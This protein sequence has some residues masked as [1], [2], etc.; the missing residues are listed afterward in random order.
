MKFSHFV[1][2][3]V[4]ST[5]AMPHAVIPF[6]DVTI[7]TSG[8]M[9][10]TINGESMELH[11]GDVIVYSPGDVRSRDAGGAAT[12]FSFNITLKEGTE[13]PRFHGHLINCINDEILSLVSL[14]E[15]FHNGYTSQEREKCKH[16]FL[17][18]YYIL[19]EI[20]TDAKQDNYISKIKQYVADHLSE[21]LSLSGVSTAVFLSPN[22]CNHIFKTQTGETIME[23]ALRV[24][25]ERARHLLLTSAMPLSE[26]AAAL[27][28]KQ[29]SYFSG[30]FK[31]EVGVSP[32]AFRRNAFYTNKAEE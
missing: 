3:K 10:Y 22:Y 8:V 17:M 14:Y 5:V 23:Y 15:R 13:Y 30:L 11:A 12:Y 9:H 28:Y 18:L 32:A 21:P 7:V 6:I 29:Y 19:Y 16:C 31:K 2:R 27:G 25:M 4:R 1:R 24:K 26:V 20:H